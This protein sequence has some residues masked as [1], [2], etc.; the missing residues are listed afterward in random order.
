MSG[1]QSQQP[2]DNS[3]IGTMQQ[4][5]DNPN[6]WQNL[7]NFGASTLAAA[8]ARTPQGFLAYGAGPMG[9]IGAGILGAQEQARQRDLGRSLIG[10]QGA[11]A[12]LYSAEARKA[13]VEARLQ[14]LYYNQASDPNAVNS[15]RDLMQGSG[16][17]GGTNL[18]APTLSAGTGTAPT[19]V[20][21]GDVVTQLSNFLGPREGNYGSENK[22]GYLG[23][24][25]FGSAA[26]KDA[27][28][29]IPAQGENL[30]S[31]EWKGTFRIPPYQDMTAQQFLNNPQAQETAFGLHVQN[32]QRQFDVTGLDKYYGQEVGGVPLNPVTMMAMAHLGG[33]SGLTK[34]IQSDGRWNPADA[35]GTHISD[36]GLGAANAVSHI[37]SNQQ[38]SSQSSI[39]GAQAQAALLYRQAQLLR[40]HPLATNPIYGARIEAQA[41]ASE[42]RARALEGI[43]YAGPRAGAEEA[44]KNPYVLEQQHQRIVETAAGEGKGPHG[45]PIPGSIASPEY[46]GEVAGKEAAA[47]APYQIT[48]MEAGGMAIS[49]TGKIVGEVNRPVQ[50][51]LA[52]GTMIEYMRKPSTNETV[53]KGIIVRLS[54]AAE[55]ALKMTGEEGGKRLLDITHDAANT[56]VARSQMELMMQS[57]DQFVPGAGAKFFADIRSVLQGAATTVGIKTPELDKTLGNFQAYEAAVNSMARESMV[58]TGMRANMEFR[59]MQESMPEPSQTATG[60]KMTAAPVLAKFDW[61]MARQIAMNTFLSEKNADG[62][63]IHNAS[64]IPSFEADFNSKVTPMSFWIARL[65]QTPEGRSAFQAISDKLAKTNPKALTALND[66]LNYAQSQ[67]YFQ[68]MH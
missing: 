11:R 43:A 64:D 36:Y 13:D 4:L 59:A 22:A 47:R 66:D 41:K 29:Y 38:Q 49:G 62:Y 8:N 27:G 58:G 68:Y 34:F 53:G 26:A 10:E 42:E 19:N 15:F 2:Q 31:N 32:L 1:Q 45:E 33:V 35:N 63:K 65:S 46:K 12:G 28:F 56:A 5:G 55:E 67:G 54:P 48:R 24:Y 23:R 25:Q 57:A 52:D 16:G 60:M 14:Q 37:S 9:S 20:P 51:Q 7:M 44:A 30:G 40:M 3:F 21:S 6:T 17:M 61:I 50:E 18:S 39:P